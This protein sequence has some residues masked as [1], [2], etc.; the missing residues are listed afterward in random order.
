MNA[1]LKD[2]ET[3]TNWKPFTFDGTNCPSTGVLCKWADGTIDFY[4]PRVHKG[5]LGGIRFI[6]N[7]DP[8]QKETHKYVP[9]MEGG[10]ERE[11]TIE[12]ICGSI[13]IGLIIVLLI[14]L[15]MMD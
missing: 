7:D 8:N 14:I 2:L 11:E 13:F 10:T 5:I 1:Y 3:I 15:R 6:E 4:D 12:G 9:W